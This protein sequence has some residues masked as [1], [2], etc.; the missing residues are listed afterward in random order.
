MSG[1]HLSYV[2]HRQ[3]SLSCYRCRWYPYVP[4]GHRV[5]VRGYI[6]ESGSFDSIFME[7]DEANARHLPRR[8][9]Q[10]ESVSGYI[11]DHGLVF[12]ALTLNQV[13]GR[14]TTNCPWSAETT[15]LGRSVS[16]VI[17]VTTRVQHAGSTPRLFRHP[18][19]STRMRTSKAGQQH[20]CP[21]V[22]Q[23]RCVFVRTEAH[24]ALCFCIR[25]VGYPLQSPHASWTP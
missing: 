13:R 21:V 17:L 16:G 14:R 3:T 5:P 2:V 25:G 22:H 11:A 15:S 20:H 4:G 1:R 10:Y 18:S 6:N 24:P 9:D 23:P 7:D 12:K 19:T 8:T